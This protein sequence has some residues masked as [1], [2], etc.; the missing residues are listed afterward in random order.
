MFRTTLLSL[1]FAKLVFSLDVYLH[2]EPPSPLPSHLSPT[3]AR[4]VVSHQLGLDGFDSLEELS[5]D[6]S[7]RNFILSAPSKGYSIG[8]GP[9]K[10]LLL[11]VTNEV[12][13]DIIPSNLKSSFSLSNSDK[14]SNLV[15]K[16][17]E[18]FVHRAESV[19]T[20]VF[21]SESSSPPPVPQLL[22]VFSLHPTSS[23]VEKFL[24]ETAQVVDIV[25]SNDMEDVFGGIILSGLESLCA[26]D[27]DS[28]PYKLAVELTRQLLT[29][30]SQDTR[31]SLVV[32][33]HEP[34]LFRR[35]QPPQSPFPPNQPTLAPQHP[36]SSL[37]T[38]YPSLDACTNSTS[39]CSS[40]GACQQA[41]KPTF[42]G[43]TCFVCACNAT[44]DASGRKQQWVGN[45]CERRDVSAPFALLAGTTIGV[46]ILAA[47]SIALL[48]GIG[49]QKL[50]PTLAASAGAQIA[51]SD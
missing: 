6:P 48:S 7:L 34:S 18:S 2:P 41:S 25:E 35:Q 30:V 21:S 46:I 33:A 40:H 49:S 15:S 19:Y 39:S 37:S 8:G 28:E 5:D 17:V 47:G 29:T 51:K 13:S 22:D 24:A 16:T 38:C 32:L 14:S 42:E 44:T 11:S 20:N 10:A 23:G 36:F 31:F 27:R 1:L 3:Q 26:E 12:A 50:P 43:R 9:R 45:A 4:I